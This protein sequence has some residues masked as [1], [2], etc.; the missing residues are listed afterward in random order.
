[1]NDNGLV[2]SPKANNEVLIYDIETATVGP[3]PDADKD[4]LKIFGAYSYKTDKYYV[5][6][7]SDKEF[8][9]RLIDTHKFLVGFNNVHYDDPIIKRHGISLEYKRIIDLRKIFKQR[10][11]GM[12]TKKGMLGN[13]LMR[14]SLDYITRFLDLVDD[15]DAKGD[16]DYNIFKKKHWTKKEREQIIFYTKRDLEITKKLYE[17]TEKY[18]N[19]FKEFV[20]Q[21]NV[22]KKYYLTDTMAKF[23]YKADCHAMGWEPVYN[24]D[25]ISQLKRPG[26][27]YVAYPSGEQFK[28]KQLDDGSFED[29]IIQLDFSCL[30]TDTVIRCKTK[31]GGYINKKIQNVDVGNLILGENGTE[32]IGGI[33]KEQYDGELINIELEN[34]NNVK[35]TPEHKFPIIRDGK[36]IVVEAKDILETDDMITTLSK[37]KDKNRNYKGKIMKMCEVCGK[38]FSTFPSK[39]DIKSCG[40]KDCINYLRKINSTKS[41]LGKTKFNCE[42]MRRMSINRKGKSRSKQVCKNISIGTKKNM[43][44]KNKW[45]KFLKGNKNRDKSFFK[46]IEWRQKVA[47]SRMNNIKN[48][49]YVYKGIK[50]R[51]NWEVIFAKGLDKNNIKWKY[52]PKYFKLNNGDYYLPEFYL[53]EYDK[54]VEIKG[55]MYD[56]SRKNIQQFLKEHNNLLVLSDL[57]TIK[58]E[59]VKWLR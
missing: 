35:C 51:S 8:I 5:I 7:V 22:D 21:D 19:G 9:Q 16:I 29:L 2:G 50:F 3:K 20:S 12:I 13:V 38:E 31:T 37:F 47:L 15:K 10:A 23:G 42:H 53:T 24:T 32:V 49:K 28:A 54:W 39:S 52:E 59:K 36:R 48:G 25:N 27:G 11:G 44:E 33:N 57:K 30:P 56:H 45:N 55:Y 58:D 46:T 14:Y 41:N 6:P 34:G 40:D 1:M 4:I 17:W 26:G 18:F 43:H